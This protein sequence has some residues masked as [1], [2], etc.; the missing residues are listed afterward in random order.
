MYRQYFCVYGIV[1]GSLL[2][3]FLFWMGE[4]TVQ[5]SNLFDASNHRL[6]G[7]SFEVHSLELASIINGKSVSTVATEIKNMDINGIRLRNQQSWLSVRNIYSRYNIHSEQ[8][9]NDLHLIL[10]I[11]QHHAIPQ[12]ICTVS[13]NILSTS[14]G[15]A[16]QCEDSLCNIIMF[17]AIVYIY[18]IY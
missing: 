10:Q 11:N 16:T 17:W 15:F 5:A 7:S 8:Y 18:C 13:P 6:A 1:V 12:G 14:Q 2:H 3:G 9:T 4:I